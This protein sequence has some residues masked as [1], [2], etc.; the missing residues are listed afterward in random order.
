MSQP[1]E[2]VV[3]FQVS[4][5]MQRL[6]H[7]SCCHHWS[8]CRI[9]GYTTGPYTPYKQMKPPHNHSNHSIPMQTCRGATNSVQWLAQ[10]QTNTYVGLHI[11]NH[12]CLHAGVGILIMKFYS[13][14][15]HNNPFWGVKMS[16]PIL[17]TDDLLQFITAHARIFWQICHQYHVRKMYTNNWQTAFVEWL[18]GGQVV[19]TS[20]SQSDIQ[21]LLH[22]DQWLPT[23]LIYFLTLISSLSSSPSVLSDCPE[24]CFESHSFASFWTCW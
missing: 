5:T 14:M 10:T 7:K 3:L 15:S 18:H 23:L 17:W 4:R 2:R 19:V 22:R 20:I 6:E 21:I 12:T 16:V 13:Y 8:L 24:L 1:S 11:A 9:S